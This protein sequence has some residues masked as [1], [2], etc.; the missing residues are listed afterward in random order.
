MSGLAGQSKIELQGRGAPSVMFT[1]EWGVCAEFDLQASV[2]TVGGWLG[3]T[4]VTGL[5]N[6]PG[7]ADP[8]DNHYRVIIEGVSGAGI[9]NESTSGCLFEGT[10][11]A[12]GTGVTEDADCFRNTYIDLDCEQNTVKDLDINGGNATF[13]NGNFQ[14][15]VTPNI[16]TSATTQNLTFVG[17]FVRSINLHV[18]SHATLFKGVSFS[19][20]INLGILGTGSRRQGPRNR[21]SDGGTY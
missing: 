8:T 5:Y 10:S 2:N 11:E 18:S 15:P 9:I 6:K 21:G 19:D 1:N 17:G 3:P 20:N 16:T 12:N 14:S 13:I 7:F 4:P